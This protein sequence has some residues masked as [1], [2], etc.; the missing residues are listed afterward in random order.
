MN[1]KELVKLSE[2]LLQD[3]ADL[4]AVSTM[5]LYKKGTLTA[6]PDVKKERSTHYKMLCETYKDPDGMVAPYAIQNFTRFTIEH[7]VISTV[8]LQFQYNRTC[9]YL[10]SDYKKFIDLYNETY[11]RSEP[12]WSSE[13][14]YI[15]KQ[16]PQ[17][18]I[19]HTI[20]AWV[21][22]D[23]TIFDLAFDFVNA[24]GEFDE[25]AIFHFRRGVGTKLF[26]DEKDPLAKNNLFFPDELGFHYY[27]SKLHEPRYKTANVIFNAIIK[28]VDI[29]NSQ[30]Y[31]R[32]RG[33]DYPELNGPV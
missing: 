14:D 1:E 26:R 15:E 33:M 12:I 29:Q 21:L 32:G 11:G 8:C 2:K 22:E 20:G 5:F 31:E 18:D 19:A 23:N 9:V 3:M 17:D 27:S 13:P 4:F 7:Q 10:L 30:K 6:M 28:E 25:D 16:R 24:G